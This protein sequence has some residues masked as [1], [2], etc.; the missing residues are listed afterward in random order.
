MGGKSSSAQTTGYWYHL[1]YHAGLGVGEFDAFLEFR[2]GDKAAW[3]GELTASGTISINAPNLFGGEKDQGGIVGDVDVMFGEATQT[4]N[5]YLLANLG[6]Q[7]PAWRGM[8]T[9]V[10]KGGKYG[11]NNPYPQKA[12]Y[13][14]RKIVKGWDDD[15]CWYPEKAEVP[16]TP[17]EELAI[18]LNAYWIFPQNVAGSS[19]ATFWS[20]TDLVDWTLYSRAAAAIAVPEVGAGTIYNGE[21]VIQL[22]SSGA[23]RWSN[24]F[25][26]AD[27]LDF[28]ASSGSY[29][30][31]DFQL[32]SLF[33][34][35]VLHFD[36]A[37]HRISL[38]NG[39]SFNTITVTLTGSNPIYGPELTRL[40]SGRWLWVRS[41]LSGDPGSYKHGAYSDVAVPTSSDWTKYYHGLAIRHPLVNS[42]TAVC[43]YAKALPGF[44]AG[45]YRNTG[46]STWTLVHAIPSDP[47]GGTCGVS[48]GDVMIVSASDS[49]SDRYFR[50]T[51]NGLTFSNV[52]A[53][54]PSAMFSTMFSVGTRI[55]GHT[56]S[57]G[58][59]DSQ[60]YYS[61]D[62]GDTWNEV[63]LPWDTSSSDWRFQIIYTE[64]SVPFEPSGTMN[65]AHIIYYALTQADMGR[66][67][68]ANIDEASFTASADW[69]YNQGFGL[70][71]EYDP[72]AES[73][74]EFKQRIQRVAG[75]SLT[76]SLIDGKWY[77]D[78]ANGEYDLES[79]PILT[80]DDILEFK[81]QP[82]LLD[83]AVNSV[84]I[85]Y[86][87]PEKKETIVTPPTQ[88]PALIDEYGTNHLTINFPEIP[89]GEL[90]LRVAL[91]ELTSR[92]TPLS[93]FPLKTTRKPYAWRPSTYFRLQT[94]KRGIADMVCVFGQKS[95]GELL[96]GAMSI[97]ATQDVYSLPTTAFVETEPGVDTRPSQTP[98][99]ITL[100][101]AFEAPYIDVVAALPRA[102]LAVLPA[103]VGYL[104]AVAIDPAESIDFSMF[105]QP[106]GGEYEETASGNWCPS[107]TVVEAAGPQDTNFTLDDAYRLDEVTVGMPVLLNNE[108]CRVDAIDAGALT[109]TLGRGCADTVPPWD[110]HAAGSRLWFWQAARA[111]DTTEYTDGETVDVKLLTN[112]GS[113]QL[114]VSLATAISVELASRQARPY[115]PGLFRVNGL[116]WP[117][118]PDYLDGELTVTYAHR[119]RVL[120]ADQLIDTDE[121]SIGPE[122]ST[123]YNVRYYLDAVLDDEEA[124]I[125]GASATPYTLTGYGVVRIELE[126]E[127]DGLTS[128]QMHS[129]EAYYPAVID[130][131]AASVD[132]RITFT[133]ASDESGFY[134]AGD[135]DLL[136]NA[137]THEWLAAYDPAIGDALGRAVYASATNMI[138]YSDQ[139]NNAAWN[140]ANRVGVTPDAAVAP[141]GTTTADKLTED[142]TAS[143]SHLLLRASSV[144]VT[145]ATTY[146]ISIFAKAG[147]RSWFALSE[148][149][150]VT[151]A[152]YFDLANGAVGTIQGTGSPTARIKDCG[153]G[154]YRCE[155]TFTTVSTSANLRLYLASG[156]GGITYS[157]DGSS[158]IYIWRSQFEPGSF[159][160]SPIQTVAGTVSRAVASA[161]VSDLTDIGFNAS[162]GTI[163]IRGRIPA[164]V[165]AGTD[166]R[167]FSFNDGTTSERM[168]VYWDGSLKATVT[169]GGV[170]QCSLDAGAIAAGS[171]FKLVFSYATNSFSL[172]VNGAASV[173]DPSG[174]VPTVNRL[175]VMASE[176]GTRQWGDYIEE[177]LYLPFELTEAER[178][179]WG[180]P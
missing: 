161:V 56:R 138:T 155:L 38:D 112:T 124:G 126:S 100:Q 121:A 146:T 9:L 54:F 47:N 77:L 64:F 5:A 25:D 36:N 6:D 44:A 164:A 86:F 92:I 26:I 1:L 24:D 30:G 82:T 14:L 145:T 114:D 32:V 166:N 83:S 132:S 13:K 21:N 104:E 20:S 42:G 17:Q 73:V 76:R 65:P 93:G 40:T 16:P 97:T 153:D 22:L 98:E 156:N 135:P 176:V 165:N 66:E 160:T 39:Q 95:S 117:Q 11:A 15:A 45:I 123:T 46:S 70:C 122:A 118:W 128:W 159:A 87:D 34:G 141:D 163:C 48:V 55:I 157:G 79:L 173:I 125:T 19:N 169:D 72:S 80:D 69:Y 177:I 129:L 51:D 106:S 119:D 175:T 108:M 179:A 85:K 115:P 29:G 162:A 151:A 180:T 110:G 131:T 18:G 133:R 150:G 67:S 89:T 59:A 58:G 140:S 116:A 102:E 62:Y 154:W 74:E 120:Q 96:S 10:F 71:T 99:V 33:G 152:A 139:F 130:F 178:I 53:N 4:A 28:T 172:S 107:A 167:L 142:S 52:S 105:V 35:V 63:T 101:R 158:G 8:A 144:I 27:G 134:T 78:V 12:S 170:A 2:G 127:R 111:A 171:S 57:S 174:S 61:D 49:G 75:C 31:G 109:I 90:A 23:P 41:A 149:T 68:T 91:R 43:A 113:Q 50:S 84:S 60:L 3:T 147:E 37:T 7:V 143:S 136:S 94:P 103:D 168:Y 148:G 81:E 137:T 88:A